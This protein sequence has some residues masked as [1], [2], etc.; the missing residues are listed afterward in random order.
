MKESILKDI[1]LLKTVGIKVVLVHGGGPA[2]GELLEKY[3]QKANLFK[4]CA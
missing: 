1:L 2:I 4:V 3:E